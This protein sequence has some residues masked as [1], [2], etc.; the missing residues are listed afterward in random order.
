MDDSQSYDIFLEIRNYFIVFS[1]LL[2]NLL[3]S[4]H[5]LQL[6]ELLAIDDIDGA[7]LVGT[8]GDGDWVAIET[9]ISGDFL[10]IFK[11]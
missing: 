5:V 9:V 2:F 7:G 1:S 3:S 8:D 4:L 10:I 11:T 6:V